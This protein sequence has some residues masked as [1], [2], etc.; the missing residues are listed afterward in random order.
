MGEYV[1]YICPREPLPTSE[2]IA[3]FFRQDAGGFELEEEAHIVKSGI[4]Y[5]AVEINLP[6]D[7]LF[8]P[9]L[10]EFRERVTKLGNGTPEASARVLGVLDET[11]SIVTVQLLSGPGSAEEAEKPVNL[12][13]AHFDRTCPGMVYSSV[14]GFWEGDRQILAVRWPTRPNALRRLWRSLTGGR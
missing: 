4:V 6:G 11:K 14:V 12:L 2:T 8:A 13:F 7:D 3:E 9:E 1:H 10:E 5:A